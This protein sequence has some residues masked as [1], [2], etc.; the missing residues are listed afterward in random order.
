M[1]IVYIS[2]ALALLALIYLAVSAWRTF[3][4]L[5]PSLKSLSK[6]TADLQTKMEGITKETAQMQQHAANIQHDV[7]TRKQTI[8][9][10]ILNVKWSF[11][12]LKTLWH[13]D[14]VEKHTESQDME[15]M[16][17]DVWDQEPSIR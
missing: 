4:A 6:T 13:V 5:K 10:V 15:D 2:L 11:A 7:Q 17:R 12:D 16:P 8:Q 3:K 9:D 14:N 1:M